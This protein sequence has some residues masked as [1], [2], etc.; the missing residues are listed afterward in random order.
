MFTPPTI[1][2]IWH[3]KMG[4]PDKIDLLVSDYS[5]YAVINRYS[6]LYIGDVEISKISALKLGSIFDELVRNGDDAIRRFALLLKHDDRIVRAS[7]SA[8]LLQEKLLVDKALKVLRKL[9]KSDDMLGFIA[10]ARLDEFLQK[11]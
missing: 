4:V 6:A 9:S 7:A 2:R 10:K 1:V 5:Y 8:D 3:K 11:T